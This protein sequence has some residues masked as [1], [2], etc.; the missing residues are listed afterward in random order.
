MFNFKITSF[1][2]RQV[3]FRNSKSENIRM[4]IEAVVI[5]NKQQS[6]VYLNRLN[7]SGSIS[8]SSACTAAD[9]I[10]LSV[11]FFKKVGL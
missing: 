3:G 8:L 6:R 9:L 5:C 7:K 1:P 4:K 11:T 10:T 2:T